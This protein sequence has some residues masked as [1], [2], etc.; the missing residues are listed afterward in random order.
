MHIVNQQCFFN[1]ID[2]RSS[3][4]FHYIY[5]YIYVCVCVCVCACARACVRAGLKHL[6]TPSNFHIPL[7]LVVPF[8]HSQISYTHGC[9]KKKKSLIPTK[10]EVLNL[11]WNNQQTIDH[12]SAL[13]VIWYLIQHLLACMGIIRYDKYKLL[14]TRLTTMLRCHSLERK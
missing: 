14:K 5:I 8:A 13:L 11:H 9:I 10:W 4:L 7:P 6:T 2:S 12:N 1:N 3:F